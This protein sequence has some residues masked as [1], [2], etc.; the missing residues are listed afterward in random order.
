MFGGF[1]VSLDSSPLSCEY[2]ILMLPYV[3]IKTGNMQSFPKRDT[4]DTVVFVQN[5]KDNLPSRNL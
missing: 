2:A 1:V 5:T 3:C 4:I